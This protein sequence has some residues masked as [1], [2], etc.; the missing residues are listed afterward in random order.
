MYKITCL[1]IILEN[2][3]RLYLTFIFLK[4]FFSGSKNSAFTQNHHYFFDL[5]N[6]LSQLTNCQALTFHLIHHKRV[7]LPHCDALQRHLSGHGFE[8]KSQS[9][10][11][12]AS[13][14]VLL[15]QKDGVNGYKLKPDR[16]HVVT[17]YSRH[18]ATSVAP[19]PSHTRSHMLANGRNNGTR[20]VSG[21]GV[22][23]TI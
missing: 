17:C 20:W 22:A 3:H 18:P 10:V 1:C 4:F 21:L 15:H 14:P 23:G 2:I 13:C 11:T 6:L 7:S 8:F 16:A 19:H 5:S 9:P 12:R